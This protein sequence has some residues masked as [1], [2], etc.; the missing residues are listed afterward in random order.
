M[1]IPNSPAAGEVT[2]D[3]TG[4]FVA[5]VDA[6]R[7]ALVDL[8]FTVTPYSAQVQP[9]SK[10]GQPIL[11]GT[12]N[13]CIMLSE[14]YLEFLVHTANSPIGQEFLA[15]LQ[16]RAGLHLAAFGVADAASHHSKLI[17]AGTAMRPLV[18]F[19]RSVQTINGSAMA[20]FTVARLPGGDMPEGRVQILTHHTA[21]AM[22][23][24][25]WTSHANGAQALRA[26]LV[27]CPDPAEAALRFGRFLNRQ[28]VPFGGGMR[29]VLDRG[30]IEFLPEAE[31]TDLVGAAVEPGRS[32]FVGVRI[33]VSDLSTFRNLP[34]AEA[35]GGAVTLPFDPALGLGCWLFE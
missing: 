4:H 6:A 8:G 30:A 14:G 5:D 31:A 2:L 28:P 12:G 20:A 3:H 9:H 7:S 10:T 18:H 35:H 1:E 23:Q 25:R 33:S 24:P 16:R 32:S 19:S 29:L 17:S 22:W 15:G 13:I 21:S 26:L 34:G 11:T 27:S